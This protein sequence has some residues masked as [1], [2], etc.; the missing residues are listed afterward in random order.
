MLMKTDFFL[1]SRRQECPAGDLG[2]QAA[3]GEVMAESLTTDLAALVADP[4]R[5]QDIPLDVIPTML[6][7][8]ERL[9]A[10]LWTRLLGQAL[11][12]TT[13][14][15]QGLARENRLLSIPAVADLL[16]IPRGYAYELARRGQ[17]PVIRFGR[18]VRVSSVDFHEWLSHHRANPLD[19]QSYMVYKSGRRPDDR[20]RAPTN[21]KAAR[22]HTGGT[23]RAT[24]RD[25]KHRGAMG[26]G[27][28][29]NTRA[30][31]TLDPAL[32]WHDGETEGQAK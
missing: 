30:D 11:V 21:Q 12:Q 24:R 5:V 31:G 19:H 3:H 18:Y 7:E 29:S 26:A 10:V 22:V 25:R 1:S 2:R 23:G 28:S 4:A 15:S 32:D 16:G 14:Q 17:I 8:L 20:K 13:W 9:K 27:R 6:G